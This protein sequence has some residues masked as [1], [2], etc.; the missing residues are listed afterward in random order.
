MRRPVVAIAA[1]ACLA[2]VL[3][4]QRFPGSE[5]V[6]ESRASAEIAASAAEIWDEIADVDTIRGTERGR[7]LYT[8][9]GMPAPVSVS[10]DLPQEGGLR[11]LRFERD[12]TGSEIV[13]DWEPG[14]RLAALSVRPPRGIDATAT[15]GERTSASPF[16][17]LASAYDIDSLAPHRSRLT[18]TSRVG[19]RSRFGAIS[20]WWS[21]L[22]LRSAQRGF[23]SVLKARSEAAGRSPKARIRAATAARALRESA[24]PRTASSLGMGWSVVASLSGRT[25]VYADSVVVLVR[26]GVLAV[27]R[28]DGPQLLDSVT[29]NLASEAGGQWNPGPSSNALVTEWNG[30]QG[31]RR[32]LGPML[33]FTI[34]RERGASL[35]GRW[36]VFSHYLTVPRTTDNP[37]G[38]AWTY[39]HADRPGARAR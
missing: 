32:E 26:D 18:L 20:D 3:L 34:Q 22:V 27:Q 17:V 1:G 12:I 19:V 28:L 15:S 21:A 2:L 33:R 23:L 6:I 24:T 7:A 37:Y 5:R 36:V 14:R 25:D 29:A 30:K 39:T 4:V 10:L 8:T 16:A 35:E 31:D 11:V 38:T 9:L 13:V